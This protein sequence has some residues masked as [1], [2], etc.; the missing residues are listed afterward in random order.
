MK[1]KGFSLIELLISLVI[2]SLILTMSTNFM[3]SGFLSNS[4]ANRH[5]IDLQEF[6]ILSSFIRKDIQYMK[7]I[8][9]IDGIGENTKTVLTIQNNPPQIEFT[10]FDYADEDNKELTRLIYI[11]DNNT[12]IR[13]QFYSDQPFNK[14]DF[15]LFPL[16]ENVS[17][18]FIEAFDGERW[19]DY[20]PKS[21]IM[22]RRLP[23]AIKLTFI[24][25]KRLFE[26]LLLV[27]NETVFKF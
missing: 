5:S 27:N 19:H 2:L 12:F 24:Q 21:P 11:L 22:E 17:S 13:K 9:M 7:P 25:D 6:Q 18:L 4:A 23:R 1:S 14:Q 3:R 8:P 16:A 10:I 20:W 15:I 26:F